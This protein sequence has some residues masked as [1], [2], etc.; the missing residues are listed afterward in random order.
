MLRYLHRPVSVLLEMPRRTQ[1]IITMILTIVIWLQSVL[2]C[3]F[4]VSLP[5]HDQRPFRSKQVVS[6]E[7]TTS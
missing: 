5:T 1:L 3:Y 7:T 6:G 2:V 4:L